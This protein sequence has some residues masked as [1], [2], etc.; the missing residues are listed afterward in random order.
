MREE[1]KEVREDRQ[2]EAREESFFGLCQ[3]DETG[4]TFSTLMGAGHRRFR[5]HLLWSD[6]TREQGA[7]YDGPI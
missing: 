4:F 1:S 6:A 2:Q 3:E 7:R 5:Q